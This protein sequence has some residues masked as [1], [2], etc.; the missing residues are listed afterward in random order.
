MTIQRVEV[1]TGV[2]RR[3]RFTDAEK[4]QLVEEAFR[5]GVTATEVARRRGVDVSLLYRWR[6]RF[7][8]LQPQLPAFVPVTVAP[9][10][11]LA[12][13]APEPMAASSVPPAGVIEVEFATARLRITGTVDP[14]VITAVIATLRRPA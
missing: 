6:R 7:F 2:E 3:R 14:A 11:P 10:E 8:G 12:E 1:I 13:D 4:L 5:P 9:G